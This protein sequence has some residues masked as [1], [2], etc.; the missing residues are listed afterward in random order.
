MS[1]SPAYSTCA[2]LA[3]PGRATNCAYE[4]E[5]AI[6]TAY[7]HTAIPFELIGLLTYLKQLDD[8]KQ[9]REHWE[10][11][12]TG[13]EQSGFAQKYQWLIYINDIYYDKYHDIFV[14]KYHDI[15][16]I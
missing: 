14:G 2:G 7:V 1:I 15:Y 10:G 4:L 13:T 12:K 6:F 11:R 8:S 9:D 5:H 3:G 16:D